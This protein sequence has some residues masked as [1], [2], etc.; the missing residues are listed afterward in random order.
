MAKETRGKE[1]AVASLNPDEML[2]GGLA[3]DFRGRVTEAVYCRFDYDGNIDEPV[4]AAR[5]TI[6][7]EEGGDPIVQ[8][9]SAGN[10]DSFVPSQDGKTPC[11]E[12]EVGPF[13][14][15][16]GKRAGLNNNTN[17][18]HLMG[19]ILDA[20]EAS[21]KFKRTDLTSSLDCLE[22]LDAHWD[23]VPQKKRSGLVQE[24]E[25]GKRRASDVL[26]VS[27]VFGYGDEP[28]DSGKKKKAKGKTNGQAGK[29]TSR[30]EPEDEEEEET[31]DDDLDTKLHN[32][33]LAAIAENKGKLKK[34]KLATEVLKAL[35]KDKDKAAAVKRVMEDD[36]IEEGPWTFNEDTG[37]L[38][39]D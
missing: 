14:L 19:S 23:R 28:A 25:E 17:F 8:H 2:A 15:R 36:F 31:D 37:V 18:A 6:E 35:G 13:A 12:D 21:K 20:G 16:V 27:E 24:N 32:V 9:W 33:V 30:P 3:D 11:E 22:G 29:A 34:G 39:L 7:P 1:S 10:L 5:L 26:V 38:S 4:L